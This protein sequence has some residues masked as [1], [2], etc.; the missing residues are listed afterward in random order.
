L[1]LFYYKGQIQNFGDD[2]NPWIWDNVLPN[3]F[4]DDDSELFMGIGSIL[5]DSLPENKK[6][7]V[8]GSGYGGYSAVPKIN[9]S[10]KFHFVRGKLTAKALGI[11]EKLAV[12]D[13]AILIRSCID[14]RSPVKKHKVS[15]IPHWEST[16]YGAW[17]KVCAH[18]GINYIDPC[19]ST[20]ETLN[21]ILE[22]EFVIT[23]AMHGA[24]VADAVRTPWIAIRPIQPEHHMKWH[25]WV[26]VLDVELKPFSIP[27]SSA[28]EW[29]TGNFHAN[30]KFVGKVRSKN[31]YI[32]RF[33]PQ[34]FIESASREL[35]K[36]A[37][38]A[39]TLSTDRSIETAHER[40]LEKVHELKSIYA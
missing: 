10:W 26:S 40:M 1:K 22:S 36:I 2:I 9:D 20:H 7:I 33:F 38:Y 14:I 11:D 18:A 23:E 28:T 34:A 16:L 15:F 3:F 37:K 12:G 6:K 5:Y 19:L 17:D 8:F 29:L 24:I 25:D 27:G 13:G 30:K 21:A 4:D 31:R 35:A 39:P 32:N